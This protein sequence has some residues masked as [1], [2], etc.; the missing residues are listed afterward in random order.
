[1]NKINTIPKTCAHAQWHMHCHKLLTL[2]F[3][4]QIFLYYYYYISFRDLGKRGVQGDGYG[5]DPSTLILDNL[6]NI[7]NCKPIVTFLVDYKNN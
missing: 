3:V 2:S 4:F 1:M 6:P 7:N 5:Y